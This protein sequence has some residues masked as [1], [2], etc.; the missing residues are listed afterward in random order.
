MDRQGANVANRYK[1][2]VWRRVASSLKS[3]FGQGMTYFS[4]NFVRSG[5]DRCLSVEIVSF[6][7]LNVIK[8]IDKDSFL[9][10]FDCE[11]SLIYM[12]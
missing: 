3:D 10:K 12:K 6:Y 9:R 5:G 8:S 2:N 1:E 7:R 11:I 4:G